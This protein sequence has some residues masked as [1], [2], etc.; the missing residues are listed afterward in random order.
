[1]SESTRY[2]ATRPWLT[3]DDDDLGFLQAVHTIIKADLDRYISDAVPADAIE[4]VEYAP[5]E[6]QN[7]RTGVYAK[8]VSQSAM[9][10]LKP[11]DRKEP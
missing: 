7:D 8:V 6:A 5:V 1:M 3:W 10:T 2:M 9:V 11:S 4:A